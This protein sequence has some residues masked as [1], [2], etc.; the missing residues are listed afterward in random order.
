MSET[1]NN[2]MRDWRHLPYETHQTCNCPCEDEITD[3]VGAGRVLKL[4]VSTVYSLVSQ[5][6]LKRCVSRKQGSLRFHK[7]TL[8]REYFGWR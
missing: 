7:P 1:R 8:I 5:G 2:P 4:S 3:V 6:R